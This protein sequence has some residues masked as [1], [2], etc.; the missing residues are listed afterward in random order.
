MRMPGMDG[1]QFLSSIKAHWPDST[2]G[3]LTGNAD[4]EE[5]RTNDGT[6]VVSKGQEVTSPLLA[7]LK[8]FHARRVI[9]GA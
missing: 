2:R 6:L 1:I 3:M 4:T 9:T 5:L 7:K 8:N